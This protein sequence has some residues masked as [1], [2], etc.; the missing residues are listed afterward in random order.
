MQL[1]ASYI[2][3]KIRDRIAKLQER[4]IA[5]ELRTAAS[6]NGWNYHHPTP[7]LPV[8]QIPPY[9]VDRKILSPVAEVMPPMSNIY[10]PCSTGACYSCNDTIPPTPAIPQSS[11][12]YPQFEVTAKEADSSSTSSLSLLMNSSVCSP[13]VSS[14]NL[15][16]TQNT[17]CNYVTPGIYAQYQPELWDFHAQYS[18]SNL[19]YITTGEL[20]SNFHPS[21]C[22]E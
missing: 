15:D 7:P 19:Y 22:D 3:R 12:P 10:L 9:D 11:S 5:S 13:G 4:V 20:S 21:M 17:P 8:A 14:V 1:M 18:G 6:I 2:G 16:M